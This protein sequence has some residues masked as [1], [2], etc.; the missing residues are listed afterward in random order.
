LQNDAVLPN[1]IEHLEVIEDPERI[2]FEENA[3]TDLANGVASLVHVDGPALTAQRDCCAQPR[4]AA[5]TND[6][7]AHSGP[8]ESFQSSI[9]SV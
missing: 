6:G 7:S 3:S 2:P 8:A 4:N 5:P 9:K 1:S